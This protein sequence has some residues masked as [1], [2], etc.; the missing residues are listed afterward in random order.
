MDENAEGK[1]EWFYRRES[2][3]KLVFHIVKQVVAGLFSAYLVRPLC[4]ISLMWSFMFVLEFSKCT[5]LKH[6]NDCESCFFFLHSLNTCF[7]CTGVCVC[8]CKVVQ[9]K[10]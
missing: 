6:L 7:K 3:G 9:E 10:P 2:L 4:F 5:A 8:V 1:N